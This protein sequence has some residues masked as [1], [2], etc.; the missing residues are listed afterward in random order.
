MIYQMGL[1]GFSKFRNTIR[2]LREENFLEASIEA[3][4]SNWAGPVEQG[5]TPERAKRH[6]EVIKDPNKFYDYYER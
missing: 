4:D 1:Q 5:G 3:L 2:L 6:S